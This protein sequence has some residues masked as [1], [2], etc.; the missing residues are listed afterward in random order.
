MAMS[1]LGDLAPDAVATM[2]WMVRKY[3]K[4]RAAEPPRADGMSVK[5]LTA[6]LR[7]RLYVCVLSSLAA[8]VG[9]MLASAGGPVLGQ[10]PIA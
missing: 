8:G 6:D 9:S 5:E 10:Q 7:D 4:K 1:N 2:D 3:K